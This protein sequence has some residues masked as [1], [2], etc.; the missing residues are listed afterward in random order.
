MFMSKKVLHIII[1]DR[2]VASPQNDSFKQ[3]FWEQQLKAV[4]LALSFLKRM[5]DQ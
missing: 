2:S 4:Q 5:V 1:T 3:I